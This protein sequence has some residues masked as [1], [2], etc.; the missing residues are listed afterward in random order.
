LPELSEH[1]DIMSFLEY[2]S[3]PFLVVDV[4]AVSVPE[5]KLITQPSNDQFL[6]KNSYSSF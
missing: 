5:P 4:L 3:R 2:H 1:K 6:V